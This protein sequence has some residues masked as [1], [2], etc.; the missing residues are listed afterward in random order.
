MEG[1]RL[2]IVQLLARAAELV[3]HERLD[4]PQKRSVYER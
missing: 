3:I 1:H 4:R 2:K